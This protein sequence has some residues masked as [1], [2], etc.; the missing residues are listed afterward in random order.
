MAVFVA[1]ESDKKVGPSCFY[2]CMRNLGCSSRKVDCEFSLAGLFQR[3]TI[4]SHVQHYDSLLAT[5]LICRP[6][7][8]PKIVSRA[9]MG[10]ALNIEGE[11]FISNTLIVLNLA[12][13]FSSLARLFPESTMGVFQVELILLKGYVASY[14]GTELHSGTTPCRRIFIAEDTR[15]KVTV[16]TRIFAHIQANVSHVLC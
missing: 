12:K 15:N 5:R 8:S 7:P 14:R 2:L 4:S 6:I 10:N 11:I 9:P 13:M 3:S 16:D 1:V